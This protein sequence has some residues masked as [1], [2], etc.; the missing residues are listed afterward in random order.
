MEI[1][2]LCLTLILGCIF[3]TGCNND[4]PIPANES[5]MAGKWKRTEAYI[6]SGEPQY[7]VNVENGEE[8]EFFDNN[9]FSSNRF[10]EC[11]VRN[12]SIDENKLLL[13]Y[14]CNELSTQ[15]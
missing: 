1:K 8:I 9:A 5:L 10:T 7:W 11:M 4:E 14:N 3:F 12:F 2:K 13:K 6:R 15:S